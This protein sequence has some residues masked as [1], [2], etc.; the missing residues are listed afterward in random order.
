MIRK[1][2]LSLV[3]YHVDEDLKAHRKRLEGGVPRAQLIRR[4]KRIARI[5]ADLEYEMRRW[6]K[7]L[8]DF[9]PMDAREEIGVLMSFSGMESALKKE[10]LTPELRSEIESLSLEDPEFRMS[11]LEER[12][13]PRDKVAVSSAAASSSS[14]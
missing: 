3:L 1:Q 10:I 11:Q 6:E 13:L 14:T 12:L 8:N 7:T 5:L 4:L 9:L 2:S